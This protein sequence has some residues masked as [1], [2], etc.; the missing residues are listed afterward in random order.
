[1]LFHNA[2]IVTMDPASA[3]S[4]AMLVRDGL[5]ERTGEPHD[6]IRLAPDA[7]PVDLGGRFVCPGFVDAHNH[8]S[9]TAL[10]PVSVDCRTPPVRSIDGLLARVR[11]AVAS[12]PPGRWLRGHGYDEATLGSRH[13][14][15]ADLDA[16]APDHPVVLVHWTVHRCVAN[17]AALRAAGIREDAPNP[18]GGRALRDDAGHLTGLLYERA[19]DPLQSRSIASYAVDY[20]GQL[21]ALFQSNAR[22]MLRAGITAL[23]DTYVHPDL[24]PMYERT[25]LPLTIR[26]FCGSPDGL[27]APPWNCTAPKDEGAGR[28]LDRGVKLF[29]DGGGNTTAA[30][31]ASG[32][33]P[34]FLFY[35]QD[36]LDAIV[37]RAHAAHLPIA[38]HAAGDIAV[39][40][41]L[42]A[43]ERA[44]RAC[45]NVPPRFR[46]EHAIT[47]KHADID[48]LRAL[49][50]AV[51]T[52]PEA[53]YAAG[54]RLPKA[55]LADGIRIAPFRDLLD[56]GVTLA[57][58]S[59]SPCYAL[60]PLWQIWC[61]VS[62]HTASGRTLDDGQA[63]TVPEALDAY[64]RAGA[65]AGFDPAGGSLQPGRRADF[66]V[67]SADP[68]TVP[69]DRWR[70]LTVEE[71]YLA[72]RLHGASD[73]NATALPGRHQPVF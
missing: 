64:T 49:H 24:A 60:S 53:V 18:S 62:R 63:L 66:V 38:I 41:A 44:Q 57:F 27:F 1:M 11:D 43:I 55:G 13:P 36:E 22:A 8:F 32:R 48:R 52:Q 19:T 59:D 12:L 2:T 14:T 29:V 69:I 51:V 5:V 58:S 56:A 42:D 34:R 31:L 67:L 10:E 40:M 46:I 45:P 23:G 71:T 54:D 25:D 17:S 68:R 28:I 47:L 26:P 21:P 33:P 65:A 72:G 70:S 9:L 37:E 3:Q 6:L 20:A 4:T 50:V 30:S 7:V 73:R 39:T 15:R 61:A 35:T 16:A